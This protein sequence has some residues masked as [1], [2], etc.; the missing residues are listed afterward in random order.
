MSDEKSS[1]AGHPARACGEHRT[2]GERAWCH[3][4]AEWCYPSTGCRGCELATEGYVLDVAADR[5]VHVTKHLRTG[6]IQIT[7]TRK[8]RA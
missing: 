6:T 4:C 3:D 2:T 8:P 7:I 5:N 1:F